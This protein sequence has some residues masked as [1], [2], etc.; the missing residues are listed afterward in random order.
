MNENHTYAVL[1][2]D[3]IKSTALSTVELDAVRSRLL[4]SVREVKEWKPGLV[5]SKAEFFRG[6]SWQ[7]LLSD[8]SMAL[9]VAVFLRA[10]MISQGK[11]DTRISIGIGKTESISPNRVSLS[12]GEAFLLSG[13]GLDKMISV[14]SMMISISPSVG[15]LF[16]WLPVVANLC[17]ALIRNWTERQAEI[18]KLAAHPKDLIHE[19]IADELCPPVSKQAVTKALNGANWNP[20]REAIQ[21]FERTDWENLKNKIIYGQP[22]E[23]V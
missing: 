23:V 1:T 13:I 20:L 6:D 10:S 8:P 5:K 4:D 18:V 19:K 7:I 21:T 11:A 2:G 14:T 16:E 12:T 17:D 15:H 3:I 9:R 22:L